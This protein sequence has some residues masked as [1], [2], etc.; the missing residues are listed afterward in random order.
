MLTALQCNLAY[1]PTREL[2]GSPK[3]F[4]MPY[5]DVQLTTADQ[6][7]L[8]GWYVPADPPG[9]LT[10]LFFHGNAGNISH[11]IESI[12]LFHN[13]GLNV[14]IIDYRGYGRSDGRPTERGT[15][16]DAEAAWRYLTE[17]KGVKPEDIIIFGRSLGGAVAVELATH[18]MPATLI[19]ESTFTSGPA[20]ARKL[21]PLFPG[22]LCF[23]KYD[24]LKRI[25]T[26]QC[27]VLVIHSPN[28]DIVPYEHGRKLYAAAPSPKQFFK[29]RGDHNSG[30][31]QCVN[32]YSAAIKAFLAET[33]GEGRKT[34][35]T[36][37]APSE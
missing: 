10:L 24:S 22:W 18:H 30:F 34:A 29:L 20:M 35:T 13:L 12:W 36:R 27:P 1:H 33:V 15:Y 14:F 8:H 26:V 7:K 11:R 4:S 3:D 32:E 16:T 17:T 31:L 21:F 23:I 19:I 6:I 9:E 28:D 25:G 37:N 2:D 5:E